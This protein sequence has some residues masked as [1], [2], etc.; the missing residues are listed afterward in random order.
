MGTKKKMKT[1][2][3][4]DAMLAELR[5]RNELL[6]KNNALLEARLT[7]KNSPARNTVVSVPAAA[8]PATAVPATALPAASSTPVRR[9][10]RRA[11]RPLSNGSNAAASEERTAAG[12]STV[13][14]YRWIMCTGQYTYFTKMAT[15]TTRYP[16]T[17]PAYST[18]SRTRS[19][20]M[21][22]IA[23]DCMFLFSI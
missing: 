2:D 7:E 14:L 5:R 13:L 3:Q 20:R 10:R 12:G 4:R 17:K 9:P 6:E 8:V 21:D 19:R 1:S 22:E 15:T 18:T 11:K 16:G 23:D